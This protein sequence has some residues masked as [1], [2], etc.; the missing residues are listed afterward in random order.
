MIILN[1]FRNRN[2]LLHTKN[3]QV[4]EIY[5][6]G[7]YFYFR[8]VDNLIEDLDVILDTPSKRTLWMY[9][10]PL[11]TQMHQD[12]VRQRVGTKQVTS[13]QT[14]SGK[15]DNKLENFLVIIDLGH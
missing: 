14:T 15:S 10:I 1:L 11:L 2:G 13:L 7:I 12:V 6:R 5:S 8:N 3:E 4:H 9:I